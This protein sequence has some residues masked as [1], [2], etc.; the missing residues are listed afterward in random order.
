MRDG[1]VFVCLFVCLGVS[2]FLYLFL[3]LFVGWFVCLFV[4]V[5]TTWKHSTWKHIYRHIYQ[6]SYQ[7]WKKTTHP[8]HLACP[9]HILATSESLV[10]SLASTASSAPDGHKKLAV[11]GVVTWW[12]CNM[13]VENGLYTIYIYIYILLVRYAWCWKWLYT[14]YHIYIYISW[15]AWWSM[16]L[17]WSSSL[18]SPVFLV[19]LPVGSLKIPT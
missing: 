17:C 15:Y 4:C 6:F 14:I 8:G 1:C 3:C 19:G 13:W 16:S 10:S 9:S 2:F 11:Q 18:A 12:L 5:T 7:N